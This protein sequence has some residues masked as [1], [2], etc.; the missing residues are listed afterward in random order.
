VDAYKKKP[1]TSINCDRTYGFVFNI[2]KIYML[3]SIVMLLHAE[4]M[5]FSGLKS[6]R[7]FVLPLNIFQ[8]KCFT[9]DNLCVES[10]DL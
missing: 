7:K 1:I 8:R 9:Y 6:K 2:L 3:L 5:Y 10:F 4:Y